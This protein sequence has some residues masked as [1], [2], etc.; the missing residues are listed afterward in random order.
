MSILAS[1]G[2]QASNS[3]ANLAD[4]LADAF[5]DSGEEDD[6]VPG[7]SLGGRESGDASKLDGPRD[8]GVDVN[9][10]GASDGE[11]TKDANLSVPS[12]PRRGHQRKGSEYDGSEYGSD[13]DLDAAGLTANLIARIDAVESLVRRGTE[14]YGGPEDDVFKRVTESLRDLGSQSSVEGNASRYEL[15][16]CHCGR[17]IDQSQTHYSTYCAHYPPCTPDSSA[18]Q[19]DLP[20]AVAFGAHA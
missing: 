17:H 13:S 1:G 9:G 14:S 18:S 11:K 6:G 12:P 16:L 5:S 8:S 2:G 10:I 7:E 3:M 19:P 20:F 15:Y 4:E